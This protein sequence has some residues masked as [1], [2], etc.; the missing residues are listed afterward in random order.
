[1]GDGKASGARLERE[2]GSLFVVCLE[3]EEGVVEVPDG[4][5]PYEAVKALTA[6]CPCGADFHRLEDD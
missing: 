3:D 5:A 2:G 1:M 4:T 6:E